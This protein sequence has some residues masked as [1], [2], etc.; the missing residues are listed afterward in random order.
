MNADQVTEKKIG[1]AIVRAMD[2][3]QVPGMAV[4]VVHNGEVV[5]CKGHG[6]REIGKQD[7]VDHD[8]LFQIASVSKAFTAASL[9]LLVDEGK[10]AWE[11]KVIDYL[12]DFRM[13]D[14]WVTR[15]FTIRDLLTHRSG[16]GLGAGDLLT[17]P[18]GKTSI[19]EIIRAMRYL[20]PAT[21]FR[22]RFDYDNLLYMIAGEVLARV[23]GMSFVE[24]VESRLFAPLGMGDCRA[25]VP[26][27]VGIGNRATP[28]VLVDGELQV[29]YF[30]D[31]DL[32]AAAGGLQCSATGMTHWLR[33]WL[34][35]GRLAQDQIS[36]D[37]PLISPE[38]V[39][40]LLGPVTLLPTEDIMKDNA[41]SHM[42]AYALGWVV[43]SFHGQPIYLHSGGLWGMTSFTAMLP[44]ENLAVFASNNQSTAAPRCVVYDVLEHCLGGDRD[45]IKISHDEYI[46]RQKKADKQVAE[47]A[48]GR[49]ADSQPSLP[50]AAYV[51]T[52]RDA[53]YGYI[54]IEQ[55]DDGLFFRSARSPNLAGPLEHFQFDTFI[56]RWN[57]RQLMA[58]AYVSF[59]LT[60]E[61][62]IERIV[63]KAVSP[64]TD[65][66]YDFHDLD[67]RYVRD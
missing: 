67:L 8:T 44:R 47:A 21:S 53:W 11:D 28:H 17:F 13:Y 29:T 48:A 2:L 32:E 58:D 35:R 30:S 7:P 63:M 31:S 12:P 18:P 64:E 45:W 39:E 3:F 38:Q 22:S 51:G 43:S 20:K 52:Y 65:F 4:S 41:G 14:A 27:A 59:Y 1:A 62:L 25:S 49:Q 42:S 37:Q 50:L 10:L 57:D 46:S 23:S 33:M 56:A 9:A 15:E 61:G 40:E 6:V 5:Y 66:S 36:E 24:F 60:P 16:L 55:T 26:N 19:D 54:F 34:S